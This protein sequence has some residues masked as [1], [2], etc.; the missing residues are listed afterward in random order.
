[1]KNFILT[2]HV[3]EFL[4]SNLLLFTFAYYVLG[5]WIETRISE[6]FD[7]ILP[8]HWSGL[9]CE[10]V[11]ENVYHSKFRIFFAIFLNTFYAAA[12]FVIKEKYSKYCIVYSNFLW[13]FKSEQ[14]RKVW[15]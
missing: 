6:S 8:S 11:P 3:L 2:K 15:L 7:E 13:Y 1:M 12:C 4:L 5:Q 9:S 10:P 14:F